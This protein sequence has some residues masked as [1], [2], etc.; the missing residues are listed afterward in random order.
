MKFTV[1]KDE[2]IRHL[3]IADSIIN[4]KSPLAILLNVYI[5]AIDDG[6]I[7][8]LSYN[9]ENGVKVESTG[10]VEVSGKINLLSKKLLEVIRKLPG[11]KIVFE[12]K[13]DNETEIVIHPV[14]GDDPV[15]HL[16]GVAADTYPTFNEFNWENYIKIAQETLEE[17]IKATEF[18]VSTDIAKSAFTGT[19]IEEAVDG[20]LSFVTTDGKRLSVITREFEEKVGQIE[21]G[22]IIPQKIFKTILESL[23]TGE[24][25]FSVHSN[26]AFFKIGNVYIFTNLV[27]GK[28]PNYKDVIPAEKINIVQIDSDV[29]S[30]AIDTVSVMSDPDSGKTKIEVDGDKM[31]ISTQHPLYG[32][33][34]QSIKMSY[35]GTPITIAISYRSLLDFLRV[36]PGKSIQMIINSQ[37]SPL[38]LKTEKDDN[39]L[40]ITMPMKLNE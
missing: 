31:T 19:Y 36:V 15:F 8:I 10:V 25:Y 11:E 20:L 28:F 14:E 5:E 29:L 34:Q 21:T 27:E 33:A 4:V 12:S 26:Q 3:G 23:G 16:N 7:I 2:F 24:T 37:S 22:V 32:V 30:K 6:T 38:L 18:A 17:Q 9:G 35:N 39:F 40:Y 13:S 1:N